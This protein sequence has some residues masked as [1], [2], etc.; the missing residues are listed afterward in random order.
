MFNI[1][2]NPLISSWDIIHST[3]LSISFGALQ[4]EQEDIVYAQMSLHGSYIP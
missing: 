1:K 3:L 4:G 2:S